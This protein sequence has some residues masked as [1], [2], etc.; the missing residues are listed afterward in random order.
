MALSSFDGY[1]GAV[2]P[3]EAT[4]PLESALGLIR[5]LAGDIGPR[6]PCSEAEK[7]AADALVRW[8][9]EHGVE[10]RL[11]PFRGYPTFCSPYGAIFGTALAGG[12]LQGARRASR[13]G[14]LLGL[15]AAL[16]AALEGD[17]RTT[18]VSD[19]LS[20]HPSVNVVGR[21]PSAGPIWRIVCLCAHLDTTRS[22]LMFHR[23]VVPYLPRLL[24]IPTVST[25]VLGLGPLLRRMP[26]GRKLR[27]AAIAG[28]VFALAMLAERELRGEDVPG[29]NDNASG[30]AVAAQ[31]AAECAAAPLEHTE[32]RL[33]ITSC[34]E[35]GLLGAQAYARQHVAAAAGTVFINFDTVATD[36]PLT[37]ILEEGSALATRPASP[38]LIELAERIAARRPELALG[39]ARATPGLP[40]DATVLRARGWEAITFLAQEGPIPHYHL[41]TDTVENISPDTVGRALEVG[42]EMLRELD[43]EAPPPGQ[44]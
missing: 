29:A 39:P 32:I 14:D 13:L 16:A 19:L 22:G 3:A 10:A 28:V 31:L 27:T 4:V 26:G 37:Y 30:S 18:P 25:P 7:R 40:T 9:G 33:L 41:P 20:R 12:L 23:R 1:G 44:A 38:L 43:R 24:M 35:S 6:R 11:E 8:L 17:L 42:R 15:G 21:V 36:A 34:E 2:L 5:S